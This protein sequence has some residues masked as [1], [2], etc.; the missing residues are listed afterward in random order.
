MEGISHEALSL[1]G[2]L[3]LNKLI[4][5]FDDNHITI[6]GPTE[7]AVSDDQV[8][9]FHRPWLER[10]AGGRADPK[11]VAEAIAAARKSDKPSMIA[12]RTTIGFGAPK[13]A[14]T[15]AAHGSPLGK[16]E[17]AGRPRE[18]RLKYPP[19][20][21]PLDILNAWRDVGKRGQGAF[22]D[23]PSAMP[24]R[25]TR[26]SSTAPSRAR[27]RKPLPAPSTTSRTPSPRRRRSS[28]P[29]SPRSAS[30]KP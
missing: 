30:S 25:P 21:I 19:F 6:D 12:C 23:G 4:V 17:I 18:A 29:G 11:A 9:A 22:A 7:L 2:H 16:E 28:R 13:K 8:R 3:K 1:A 5:L 10:H 15:A 27:C 24:A 20:E 14:G 26:R